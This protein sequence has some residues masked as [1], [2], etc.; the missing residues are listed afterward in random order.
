MS[1]KGTRTTGARPLPSSFVNVNM[2]P[3]HGQL[4]DPWRLG[5]DP[6]SPLDTHKKNCVGNPRCMYGLGEGVKGIWA[7]KPA[8]LAALG[9][10]PEL[11]KRDP[12]VAPAGLFNLGA[13]C[14]LASLVQAL[15]FN[16]KFRAVVYAWRPPEDPELKGIYDTACRRDVI[17]FSSSAPSE[18]PTTLRGRQIEDCK[19]VAALQRMFACL[20]GSHRRAFSPKEFVEV[21]A[22][23]KG[24][25]QDVQVRNSVSQ[26]R[27]PPSTCHCL[28][29]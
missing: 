9:A 23:E 1:K 10:D 6:C 25:Q 21:F 26:C 16:L 19:Q 2:A 27:S 17:D 24:V 20:Q 4:L 28:Q 29:L 12:R 14:Y 11:N 5:C 18:E 3:L 8:L 22:I 7:K 15:F 13:T